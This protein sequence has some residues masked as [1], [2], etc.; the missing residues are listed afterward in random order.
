MQLG[1]SFL[2]RRLFPVRLQTVNRRSVNGLVFFQVNQLVSSSFRSTSWSR[3]LSGQP[4]GLV[5][6]QVNQLVSSSF[7]S[8]SWSR[9]LSGQ[10][11]GLVFFQVNQLVSSSFR[12]TSWLLQL[13]RRGHVLR[14]QRRRRLRSRVPTRT[15]RNTHVVSARWRATGRLG[16]ETKLRV[17]RRRQMWSDV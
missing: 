8:T 13:R 12:S 11:V 7:R 15:C 6:F 9:L 2:L 4:V 10:P 14:D 5:F 3:L 17:W 1:P 16:R